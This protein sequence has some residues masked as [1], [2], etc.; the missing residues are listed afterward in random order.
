MTLL[1]EKSLT[2]GELFSITAKQIGHCN[3]EKQLKYI[4]RFT[5]ARL[6]SLKARKTS[7]SKEQ[8]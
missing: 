7:E 1:K 2:T 8:K 6:E 3:D 4:I 5:Q